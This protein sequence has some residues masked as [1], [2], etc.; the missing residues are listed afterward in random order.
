MSC[1]GGT[2][3]RQVNCMEEA[4]NTKIKVS[5]FCF[6]VSFSIFF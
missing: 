2:R 3:L 5:L 6:L 1:G 4:N